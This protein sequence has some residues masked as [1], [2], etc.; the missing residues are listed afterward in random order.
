MNAL[1]PFTESLRKA[2]AI[3][4]AKTARARLE[5]RVIRF[6]TAKGC[7][8]VPLEV[9]AF[10]AKAGL[11]E[12][13]GSEISL[14]DTGRR[15]ARD[16]ASFDFTTAMRRCEPGSLSEGGTT[17]TVNR[18]TCES[19][20]DNLRKRR[21]KTGEPYLSAA[22]WSAG[23]RL[24]QDFTMGQMLPSIGMRWSL[25]PASTKGGAGGGKAEIT[26]NA[27]AARQRV[28]R[29]LEAVGPEFSGLLVDVCCF[30]KG[31][32]QVE[33]ERNWPQRSA[34]LLLKTGLSVLA[35]HYNPPSRRAATTRVWR[36]PVDQL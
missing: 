9:I 19:P 36:A 15:A 11:V 13:S 10:L 34:K 23:D 3:L 4:S 26:D 29:A 24:R 20:I 6:E 32:E 12:K 25:E 18:M 5:G 30:L 1:E 28:E 8:A 27:M 2:L 21:S 33:A 16:P 7:E 22:E 14:T 31:L 17:R 35:R